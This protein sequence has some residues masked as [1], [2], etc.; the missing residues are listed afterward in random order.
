MA[1]ASQDRRALYLRWRPLSFEDVVDQ[2]HVVRTLRNA[3]R[4]GTPAHAY[5]FAGPRGTGKTSLARILYRAVNCLE[6]RDGNPCG[7]CA[8]C[9]NALDGRTLDLVEID[10]ASNRGIDDIRELREKV[11]F[12]PS[13]VRYRVYI[14]DEAHELTAP[15]WDAFLKTLEEP[16]PH[17]I[18]VLATT[19]A[20]RVPG[21]IV[22]RCQRFDFRRIRSESIRDRLLAIAAEEGL[23]LE[24]AAADRLARMARGGLR[25]A[26]SLLDQ[27][28]SFTAGRVD[29]ESLREALG[30]ADLREVQS[31][32]EAVARRDA[33]AALDG[34]I[35]AADAGA[36]LR[37]LADE[38]ARQ[39][40]GLLFARSGAARALAGEYAADEVA[41][42]ESEADRWQP[43]ILTR[44]LRAIADGLVRIRD[45]GQFQLHLELAVVEAAS[46]PV[47]AP[48][49]QVTDASGADVGAP[50]ATTGGPATRA[51]AGVSA[52]APGSRPVEQP[53]AREDASVARAGSGTA[54]AQPKPVQSEAPPVPAAT[55]EDGAVVDAL[56]VETVRARWAQVMEWVANRNPL[57]HAY[58]QPVELGEVRDDWLVLRFAFKVHHERVSETR[59]RSLVE[60]GCA[61]VFGRE[62]RVRCEYATPARPGDGQALDLEDPVLKFALER[63]GGQA[64]LVEP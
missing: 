39:L 41:W 35:A 61:A 50:P 25:D 24:S 42:L 47:A 46:G 58:L 63:F 43:D 14:V 22:S 52:S 59:N 60:Q 5:L 4:T 10:A 9:R 48:A 18:F 28:A 53:T 57:M 54:V 29:L 26:I 62:L 32:A 30:L 49:R 31:L 40:R 38:L 44:L 20:H 55:Q 36:D 23:E 64:E 15:A 56:D 37:L 3:V 27:S 33:P 6:P 2:E 17:A 34:L 51:P 19:E 1:E 45:S 12:S 13:E 16:P 7:R 8:V 21:T 11:A